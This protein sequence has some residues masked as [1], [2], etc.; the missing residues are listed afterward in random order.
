MKAEKDG[1]LTAES[2]W[3]ILQR[4]TGLAFT[5][6]LEHAGVFKCTDEGR[7]AFRRFTDSL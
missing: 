2:V 1:K 4:E 3:P 5:R 7:A 6:G